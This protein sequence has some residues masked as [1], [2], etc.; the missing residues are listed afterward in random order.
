MFVA[1]WASASI[2]S[3][4]G[5]EV[6][7]PGEGGVAPVAATRRGK[8][9]PQAVG[10]RLNIGYAY[11][12]GG[13]AKNVVPPAQKRDAVQ[14]LQVGFTIRERRA[15]A[16]IGVS[17]S[18]QRYRNHARDQTAVQM[19]LRDLAAARP[20]W[21]AALAC[22]AATCIWARQPQARV[23]PVSPRWQGVAAQNTEE[24]DQCAA[25]CAAAGTGSSSTLEHG[26]SDR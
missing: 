25:R 3:I 11:G 4:A 5:K 14:V 21:R 15:C 9:Q 22:P 8:P 19:R 7:G 1:S 18:S 20:L 23:P 12:A 24:T 10:G 26:C 16:V 17:R 2:P 6:C 13:G